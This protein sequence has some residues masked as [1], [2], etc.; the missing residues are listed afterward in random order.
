MSKI[1]LKKKL[2]FQRVPALTVRP[3]FAI[4][5]SD[6]D[7]EFPLEQSY[8]EGIGIRLSHAQLLHVGLTKIS[9]PEVRVELHCLP[10]TFGPARLHVET[11]T[12]QQLDTFVNCSSATWCSLK[13]LIKIIPEI[14]FKKSRRLL[15]QAYIKYQPKVNEDLS[16]RG[17]HGIGTNLGSELVTD[18]VIANDSFD[19]TVDQ[20]S[21]KSSTDLVMK[22]DAL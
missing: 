12:L 8:S 22:P 21:S 6:Q 4:D 14:D 19:K 15:V 2:F 1:K 10:E 16:T 17:F 9:S 11:L 20:T 18:E 7:R 13:A 3:T 5:V